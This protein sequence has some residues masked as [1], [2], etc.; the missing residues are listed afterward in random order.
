MEGMGGGK[1]KG[2]AKGVGKGAKKEYSWGFDKFVG[3]GGTKSGPIDGIMKILQ[4]G[5]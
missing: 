4:M 1:A 5:T 2:A 3:F